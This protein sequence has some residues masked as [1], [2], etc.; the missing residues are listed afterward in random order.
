LAAFQITA[1]FGFPRFRKCL[2]LNASAFEKYNRVSVL[3]V[4][5]P[6]CLLRFAAAAAAIFTPQQKARAALAS[7]IHFSKSLPSY[8]CCAKTTLFVICN[9]E[10]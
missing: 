10:V 4:P 2:V 1:F 9:D 6:V 7:S 3:I 8:R 5:L